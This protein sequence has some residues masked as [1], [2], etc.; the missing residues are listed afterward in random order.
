MPVAEFLKQWNPTGKTIIPI[1]THG[2]GGVGESLKA[3]EDMARGNVVGRCL[4]I[5]S[6]D[7]PAARQE[8]TD[9]IKEILPYLPAR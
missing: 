7:I 4:D 1:V 9:Y 8:I 3:V 6:S 5:Y 2:G